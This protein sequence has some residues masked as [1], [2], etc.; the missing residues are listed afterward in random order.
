VVSARL[1]GVAVLLAVFALG[2]VAGGKAS[3]VTCAPSRCNHRASQAPL[4][5]V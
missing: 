4:K 5:P 1:K 2:S 3:P